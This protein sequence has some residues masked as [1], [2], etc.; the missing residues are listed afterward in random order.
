MTDNILAWQCVQA[1]ASTSNCQITATSSATSTIS[2]DGAIS[3]VFS[4][5]IFTLL[6]FWFIFD[7]IVG[8]KLR[9]NIYHDILYNT[10]DGKKNYD[11]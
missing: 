3:G 10:P 9:K 1:D 6:F 4:F 5:L 8:V 7:K 2:A 11:D